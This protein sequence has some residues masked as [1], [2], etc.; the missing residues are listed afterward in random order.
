MYW[1]LYVP[2]KTYVSRLIGR[3]HPDDTRRPHVMMAIRSID[4]LQVRRPL[5]RR[6]ATV[7]RG[8]RQHTHTRRD[9]PDDSG[10]Y[11]AQGSRV[12]R[13]TGW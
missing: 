1:T 2:M 7:A 9:G 4:V 10:D 11:D 13:H 5:R 6:Q 8:T 3:R 12:V